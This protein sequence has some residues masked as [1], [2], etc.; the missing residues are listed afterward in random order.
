M[1]PL[2]RAELDAVAGSRERDERD[3]EL[4]D[5]PG[6]AAAEGHGQS[7]RAQPEG[8]PVEQLLDAA[9]IPLRPAARERLRR[10][11]D[12]PEPPEVTT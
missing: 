1:T 9:G 10:I 3:Q 4:V 7:V 11:A 6:P 12:E 2:V 5:E 8:G